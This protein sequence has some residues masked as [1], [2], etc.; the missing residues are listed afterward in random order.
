MAVVVD[1]QHAARFAVPLE[2]PLGA[3]EVAQRGGDL[4][5]VEARP[6]SPTATAASAFCRL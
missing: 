5:E 3:V 6:R 2:P 1:D 4:L